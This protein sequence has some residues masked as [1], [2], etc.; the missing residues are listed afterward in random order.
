MLTLPLAQMNA[1]PPVAILSKAFGAPSVNINGVA[2]LTL[3]L[4][5]PTASALTGITFSDVLPAG[6][7][8][9][10]DKSFSN[11]CAGILAIDGQEAISLSG[12]TLAS[13]A[14]CVL[15]MNVMG[16]SPGVKT[17][18]TSAVSTVQGIAGLPAT[19]SI[20]VTSVREPVL[21]PIL[22]KAFG[23]LTIDINAVTTLTFTLSNPNP[24]YRLSGVAFTDPLPAGTIIAAPA[25]LANGCGGT[26]DA[27]TGGNFITLSGVSLERGRACTLFLN[28]AS[29]GAGA[30][31][32]AT[33]SIASLEGGPGLQATAPITVAASVAPTRP[34]LLSQKF[35]AAEVDK[36]GSTTLAF[37]LTNPN[38]VPALTGVGFTE[39]LPDGLTVS[40][41]SGIGNNCG[42]TAVAAPK[43]QVISI[44]GVTLPPLASCTL[45]LKIT[46]VTDGDQ[47]SATSPVSSVEGG[48]GLTA[49]AVVT[50]RDLIYTEAFQVRYVSNTPIG[51]SVI[52]ITNTGTLTLPGV[53]STTGD[54]CVNVFV[55][56]AS[57]ELISCCSCM[58]TPNGL[59]SLSARAD[60]VSTTL[61]LGVPTSLTIN[62]L[63]TTPLGLAPDGS[64]GTCNPSSATST[65]AGPGLFGTLVPGM[66]AWATTLHS[67]PTTPV[68]YGLTETEFSVA[69]LSLAHLT[70]LTTFCG[71]IQANGSGFGICKSCRNGGLAGSSR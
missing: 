27:V 70:E 44:T 51:D 64:G 2:S 39:T 56:D 55:F 33:S 47:T 42:V 54:M 45:T 36:G 21:P 28:V 26:V 23:A 43:T 46:G 4:T 40:S 25:G 17:N 5:N 61:S 8:I 65:P 30:F 13:G 38:S 50:V 34:P 14:S 67:L 69:P 9:L 6:L 35:G 1:Q 49:S 57:E 19:A 52:N 59:N 60:L 31:T 22:I 12:V 15:S 41:P 10:S 24:V 16:G 48:L 63:A 20:T 66:R 11:G 18:T 62:L 53:V 29:I 71:F 37:T 58:V 68:T 32:N 3:T 7:P